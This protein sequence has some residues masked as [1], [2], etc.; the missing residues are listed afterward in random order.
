MHP[1]PFEQARDLGCGFVGE[2]LA[3]QLLIGETANEELTL[4]QGAKQTGILFGE[5][6][7]ALVTV[8]VFN[9]GFCQFVQFSTPTSG[10]AI[11]EMNLR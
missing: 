1:Q 11:A 5:E 3:A 9:F 6:I 4:Q 2:V 8:L 7:E 10:V